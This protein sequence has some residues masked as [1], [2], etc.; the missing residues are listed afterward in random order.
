[1]VLRIGF[2]V[3]P[4]VAGLDKFFH[5][6]TNWDEYLAP[7]VAQNVTGFGI[8]AHTFMLAVGVVEIVAGLG[9]A[10]WPRVFGY[11]VMLWLW[12]IVV[13]LLIHGEYFDV[14][15]RDFGLSLG[16]FSVARMAQV[17]HEHDPRR[18]ATTDS[19]TTARTY[20]YAEAP[21]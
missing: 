6:L 12:G 8:D 17:L 19:P 2:T 15:L 16:A 13:N 7:M 20:E 11:V 10:I 1:M 5:F 3:L 18:M 9:V 4:I 14:A 21:R